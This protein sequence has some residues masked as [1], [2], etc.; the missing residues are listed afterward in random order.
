M[1]MQE[2]TVL[3]WYRKSE[4]VAAVITVQVALQIRCERLWNFQPSVSDAYRA[5]LDF[6]RW[7]SH[8]AR[9]EVLNARYQK[10]TSRLMFSLINWRRII[11][12]VFAFRTWYRVTDM[13]Y[14]CCSHEVTTLNG[15][16]AIVLSKYVI[17]SDYDGTKLTFCQ[18]WK[19][20]FDP[21]SVTCKNE[22]FIPLF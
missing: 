2:K 13:G 1:A 18:N 15:N 12:M 19:N 4:L 11:K 6:H 16:F 21:T 5:V 10:S 8:Q 3:G 7:K 17:F 22:L 9:K 14:Y 20:A